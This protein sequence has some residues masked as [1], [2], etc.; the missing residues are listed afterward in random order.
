MVGWLCGWNRAIPAMIDEE[1]FKT[2]IDRI[3]A[4]YP[5]IRVVLVYGSAAKDRLTPDSDLDIAVAGDQ[6]L[7][8]ERQV[9]LHLALASALPWDVDL[10]ISRPS[11][12]FSCNR[13]CV[14]GCC[15]GAPLAPTPA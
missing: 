8:P 10:T 2:H 4:D 6:P 14:T 3:V 9:D 11:P 7:G 1:F 15:S 5:E 12:A 13:C